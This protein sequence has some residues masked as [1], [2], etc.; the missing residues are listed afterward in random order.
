[1]TNTTLSGN[2][3]S[4]IHGYAYY[5][6]FALE[7]V[8][9]SGNGGHGIGLS[10]L[11]GRA[12]VHHVT[13]TGNTGHGLHVW[14]NWDGDAPDELFHSVIAD[15]EAG[16]C[17]CGSPSAPCSLTMDVIGSRNLDDDGTCPSAIPITGLAPEL[18]DNG[19]PTATH[20]LLEGSSAIDAVAPCALAADQRH[21]PRDDRCDAGAYEFQC[22]LAVSRSGEDTVIAF[23]PGSG[24][25]DL[26]G[27]DLAALHTDQG[28][29]GAVCLGTFSATPAVDP[30]PDPAVGACHYYLAR[31]LTDCPGA[32]YGDSSLD[33]D[34]RD[35]LDAG[36]CPFRLAA[37]RVLAQGACGSRPRRIG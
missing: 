10:L 20:A 7:N 12:E 11:Y 8:T 18:A 6:S 17:F 14:T 13:V 21:L 31:G 35:A 28:F 33:P 2:G 36:P 24:D 3:G 9:V 30:L 23:S 19:G 1:M 27:G 22:G 5:G 29:A 37:S 32:G 16:N 4:G 25:F 26:I 15:N 34:P